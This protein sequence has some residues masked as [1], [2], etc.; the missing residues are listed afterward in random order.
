MEREALLR[1]LDMLVKE[2]CELWD[3]GWVTFNWRQYTYDHVQRVRGLA[4]TLC[5]AEGGDVWVTDL[6][7]LLHDITKPYDG[8]YVTDA[9]GKRLVDAQGYWRNAYRPPTRA[10][11]VTELYERLSLQGQLHHESGAAIATHLLR[12]RGLDEATIGRVA[13]T[14]YDHL[15]CPADAPVESQCLADADTIDANVGLPAFVRNI[16]INLHFFDQRKAPEAPPIAQVLREGPVGF[17][18]PYVSENLPRWNAGKRRDFV[19]KLLTVAAQT[20]ADR[21][22]QRL[23]DLFGSMAEELG[24]F[25]ANGRRSRLEV[26]LHYMTHQDDPSIAAETAYLA[27]QWVTPETPAPVRELV[28]QI[29][30]EIAGAE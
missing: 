18:R 22:L 12:A 26:V 20:L 14:V 8:E 30:R 29:Q 23:D 21:R 19:P 7:A 17:L 11:E 6:A 25:G 3:P 9:Q 10:N 15:Q 1:D 13:Q 28:A 2:T 5:R 4:V 24:T 16:Y 27:T